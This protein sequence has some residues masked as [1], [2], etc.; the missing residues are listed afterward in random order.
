MFSARAVR[1]GDLVFTSGSAAGDSDGNIVGIGDFAVQM[2]F[3]L[4]KL[5][6]ILQTAGADL[7]DVLKLNLFVTDIGASHVAGDVWREV[8]GGEPPA[9]TVVQIQALAR[10]DYLV[11]IDAVAAVPGG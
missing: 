3:I 5:R 8:V 4:D 2:R 9:T 10:A 1:Y 11:E 6:T 7:V